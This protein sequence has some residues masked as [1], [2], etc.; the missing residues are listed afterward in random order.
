MKVYTEITFFIIF[1][2]KLM[3]LHLE[4]DHSYSQDKKGFISN[5]SWIIITAHDTNLDP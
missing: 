1:S 2:T 5:K 3:K 4:L